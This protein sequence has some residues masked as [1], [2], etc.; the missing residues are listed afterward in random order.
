MPEDV[1]AEVVEQARARQDINVEEGRVHAYGLGDASYDKGLDL[2]IQG[3]AAE[4]VI[5]RLLNIPWNT[6]TDAPH[7]RGDVLD[8]EVRSTRHIDGHLLLHEKDADD[9]ICWL[10]IDQHPRY[11]VAGS[12]RIRDGK[13]KEYWQERIKGRAC[14]FVPQSVL[15]P[16][17]FA[18][19]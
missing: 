19:F 16:P 7:Q 11:G 1:Y 4:R 18:P 12:I 15:I 8:M 3:R 14:Y 9:R 2:H 13:L 17:N 10:V 6:D 5:A